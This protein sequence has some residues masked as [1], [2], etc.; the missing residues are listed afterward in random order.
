[1]LVVDAANVV[2]SRPDGWWR[3]RPAAARRLHEQL[4]A[5]LP[6]EEVVL[7]LEGAARTGQPTGQEGPAR[8]VHA[9]GSGDDA[10]VAVAREQIADGRQVVVVTADRGL[11]ARIEAAGAAVESPSWLLRRL[12]ATR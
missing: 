7:V 9:A 8:T 6:G 4:V 5:G 10:I 11:R 12:T 1:M 3:D 2:G